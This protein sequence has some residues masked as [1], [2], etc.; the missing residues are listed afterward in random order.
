M[1]GRKKIQSD[2]GEK[3]VY[4]FWLYPSE[5]Q[6]IK[7]EYAKL[8]KL[9]PLYENKLPNAADKIKTGEQNDSIK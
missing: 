6:K 5:A 9:R 7:I 4:T 1:A 8:K 2:L 3:K